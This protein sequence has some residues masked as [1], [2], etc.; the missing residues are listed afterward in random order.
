MPAHLGVLDRSR[1]KHA[2]LT[3]SWACLA[4]VPLDPSDSTLCNWRG[5]M[6]EDRRPDALG[7]A[8]A[9]EADLL[10]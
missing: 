5:L 6:S 3:A 8:L 1:A 2:T 7:D 10:V 4:C 9:R